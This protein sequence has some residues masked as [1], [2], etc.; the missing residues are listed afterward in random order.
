MPSS[1]GVDLFLRQ[2]G[3][4]AGDGGRLSLYRCMLPRVRRS[5][6]RCDRIARATATTGHRTGGGSGRR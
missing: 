4:A 1:Y 2:A 6:H 5:S 3:F